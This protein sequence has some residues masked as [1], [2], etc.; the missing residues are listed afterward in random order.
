VRHRP[1]TLKAPQT[2][3]SL[4]EVSLWGLLATEISPP[5][6]EAPIEWLLLTTV[7]TSHLDEA[8][9]RLHWYGCRWMIEVWRRVLKTGCRIESRQLE[10]ADRLR[11]ALTLFSIIA[12]RILYATMLSRNAPD[13]P[14]TALLSTE[15][16]HALYC[17]ARRVATPPDDPPSLR[18][19][20]FWIAQIGGFLARKND[21]LPGPQ[22]LWRGL[23]LLS[24]ITHMFNIMRQ[25]K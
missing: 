23:Q 9:E 1:I 10:T 3:K 16:W 25:N 15:E 5:D 11:V 20:V 18:Q 22:V 13:L 8:I 7:P 2:K 6:G 12:W 19:A 4:G 24:H 14:C 17:H 21:G